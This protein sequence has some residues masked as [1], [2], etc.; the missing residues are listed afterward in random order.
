[1]L[2]VLLYVIKNLQNGLNQT[3]YKKWTNLSY[4][5]RALISLLL[6][7]NKYYWDWLLAV[8]LKDLWL[9]PFD[10]A[11]KLQIS[12]LSCREKKKKNQPSFVKN[13]IAQEQHCEKSIT[14][15]LWTQSYCYR[16]QQKKSHL[17]PRQQAIL[18]N[19]FS[20]EMVDFILFPSFLLWWFC[21]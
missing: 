17:L 11:N 3:T 2:V 6:S 16:G 21:F 5:L 1:M 9:L 10:T 12:N 20:P 4:M 7:L 18:K 13:K 15:P 19:L 8:I 14:P